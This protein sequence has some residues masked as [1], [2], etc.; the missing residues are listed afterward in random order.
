MNRT[1]RILAGVL[2]LQIIVGVI[3]FWPRPAQSAPTASASLFPGLQADQVTALTVHGAGGEQ[4]LLTKGT[5]GWVLPQAG[6]FPCQATKVQTF[7]DKLVALKT[8]QA[9]AQTAA[10]AKQLKVADQDY[11]TLVEF[12]LGDG[13]QH[14]LY[15]GTASGYQATHV[16]AD[17]ATQVYLAT[18]LMTTDVS[19][20][21]SG[22]I[23]TL[24]LS[25]SAEQITSVSVQNAS[26]TVEFEK[27]AAG[28]WTLK[29]LAAGETANAGNIMNLVDQ[30][31]AVNMTMPL[32][33]TEEAGF[34]LANPAAVVM[35]GTKD[36]SGAEKTITL[37]VGAQDSTDQSYVVKS[38]ESPY[39]VRANS[40]SVQDFVSKGRGDY[41]QVPEMPP[42][43]PA[44]GQ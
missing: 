29:G 20:Q 8:G 37:R 6:N 34:G 2:A 16:R 10:S 38:S 14:K 25:V 1:N 7:L 11:Q 5:D 30:V 17:G 43:P 33:K 32:G 4:L 39:Y 21:A 31:A 9:V 24:Y 40:Y 41:L 22:W 42:A 44:Q 35:V 23:D 19:V 27:D 26:G 15:M 36:Q 18:G 28:A 3:V 12:T 13:T